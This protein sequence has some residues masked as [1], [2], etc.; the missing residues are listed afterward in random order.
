ME[1]NN[2][3]DIL[4]CSERLKKKLKKKGCKLLIEGTKIPKS[5]YEMSVVLDW[6]FIN[7]GYHI[8]ADYDNRLK[9]WC[10]NYMKIGEI[11][12]WVS[13]FNNKETAIEEALEIVL[14][15]LI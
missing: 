3:I 11:S 6:V 10:G 15:H 7:F 12:S 4:Y 13:G 9:H 8:W 1:I 5:A 2:E 14:E